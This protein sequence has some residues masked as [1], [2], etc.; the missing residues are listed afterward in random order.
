MLFGNNAD[1]G[2]TAV[3]DNNND[4][5]LLVRNFLA[6]RQSSYKCYEMSAQDAP[7]ITCCGRTH[8]HNLA[9]IN[10]TV[11]V[12]IDL[13]QA[14]LATKAIWNQRHALQKKDDSSSKTPFPSQMYELR[15]QMEQD[16]RRFR[17]NNFGVTDPMVR[18]CASAVYPLGALLNHSCAPNCILRYSFEQQQQRPPVM[19]IVASRD[20]NLGEEL[21]HSYVELVCRTISR[22]EKLKALYG[23]DCDCSRCCPVKADGFL[24]HLPESYM[25][26]KPSN[27]IQWILRHHNPFIVQG[28]DSLIGFDQEK[29]LRPLSDFRVKKATQELLDIARLSLLNASVQDELDALQQAIKVLEQGARSE[30]PS[31]LYALCSPELYSARGDRLG[32]LIV[33]G[34]IEQAISECENIVAFLCLAL[35]HVGNHAILGLQLFTLGDLYEAGGSLAQAKLVFRWAYK[36]LQIS[37]GTN[38]EI[39]QLLV[40]KLR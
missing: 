28:Q 20:V 6:L 15:S 22:Q 9:K 32:S 18:V 12:A 29:I 36:I 14:H 39:T 33:A 8:F 30:E 31:P 35:N 13:E 21:T 24:F 1:I 37:H 4:A 3:I 23:F 40:E 27:L 5:R 34:D 38:S 10:K 11:L 19:E 25:T 16:L 2:T 7:P 17:V 26:M